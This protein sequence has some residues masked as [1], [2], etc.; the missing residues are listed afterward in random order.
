MLHFKL[1]DGK[2]QLKREW[3]NETHTNIETIYTFDNIQN[4]RCEISVLMHGSNVT[5]IS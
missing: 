5:V 2:S 3:I 4:V 1:Y